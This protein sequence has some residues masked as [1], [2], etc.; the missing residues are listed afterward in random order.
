[1]WRRVLAGCL[2]EPLSHNIFDPR[3]S[4]PSNTSIALFIRHAGMGIRQLRGVHENLSAHSMCIVLSPAW[5]EKV[6]FHSP[7]GSE[8]ITT[9]T[10]WLTLCSHDLEPMCAWCT[11]VNGYTVWIR[12][13][14]GSKLSDS[15]S[16]SNQGISMAKISISYQGGDL[17]QHLGFSEM[18]A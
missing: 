5:P 7:D 8:A 12:R 2:S 17:T 10:L 6:V 1:M 13:I 16:T 9:W 11:F 14:T 18:F 4:H 15:Y 3:W